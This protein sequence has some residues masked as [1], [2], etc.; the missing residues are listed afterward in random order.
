MDADTNFGDNDDNEL[1]DVTVFLTK[2]IIIINIIDDLNK[3]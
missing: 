3:Q 2:L 1:D